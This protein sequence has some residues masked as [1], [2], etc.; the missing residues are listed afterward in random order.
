MSL[1]TLL[2]LLSQYGSQY[3]DLTMIND[4]W[5]VKDKALLMV[6]GWHTFK[7]HC[8][9][10]VEVPTKSAVTPPLHPAQDERRIVNRGEVGRSYVM[11]M[12]LKYMVSSNAL[13][14]VCNDW[15][16]FEAF[17]C[18]LGGLEGVVTQ[19]MYGY[20]DAVQDPPFR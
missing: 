10:S 4:L 12:A 6:P 13:D 11:R 20:I 18:I 17:L 7:Q 3:M 2:W 19:S 9:L 8:M 5:M 16:D 14:F 15:V 1:N